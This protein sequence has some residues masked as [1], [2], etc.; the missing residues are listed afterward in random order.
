MSAKTITINTWG[1]VKQQL[2]FDGKVIVNNS[3][4]VVAKEGATK[5]VYT[6]KEG[7]LKTFYFLDEVALLDLAGVREKQKAITDI[8]RR[9]MRGELTVDQYTQAVK[10]LS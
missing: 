6:T 8:H 4:R 7:V 10:D 5:L 1:E 2:L 9:F 3:K